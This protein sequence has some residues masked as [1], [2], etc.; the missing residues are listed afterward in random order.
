MA[1]GTSRQPLYPTEA[2]RSRARLTRMEQQRALIATTLLGAVA[3]AVAS[4]LVLAFRWVIEDGQRLFLPNGELGAYEQL[5]GW[6]V[7]LLPLAGGVV[8]GLL[9]ERLDPQL[10]EVG[11]LHVLRRI[12]RPGRVTLPYGNALVQFFGGAFAVVCGHS[13]DREGPGVHLGSAAGNL[14]GRFIGTSGV[15]VYTLTACGAAASI[16]AAFNTPLAGVVFVIE[17]LHVRYRIERFI[18]IIAASV[19]GAIIS[20]ARYGDSPAFEVIDLRTGSL[21][22]FFL[23]A[24]LGVVLGILAVAFVSGT[25]RL[26]RTT[27]GWRPLQ[28]FACAGAVTGLIGLAYPQ[29]LGISYDTLSAILDNRLGA[30]L[31]TGLIVAKLLATAVAVGLR[32]PGGLIGP[33]LVIGGAAGA[34][35]GV[36][37]PDWVGFATGSE[38]FYGAMGMMAM[39]AAVLQ[40]PLA[41]LFALLELTADPHIILPGMTVVVTADLVAR[42]LLGR[43][44]VFDYLRRQADEREG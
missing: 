36:A 19:I 34:A 25:D 3:G 26:A 18:P 16:A 17:V 2:A 33:S 43:D 12:K 14:L 11:I 22:E 1:G 38:S 4:L 37:A 7:L 40:A 28:A 29:V 10:R 5:P 24:A 23:L 35:V 6:T 30:Q 8:L 15:N 31:L 42:Q 13:V 21:Y 39:M 20:R 32:V 27:R 9:F 41:A 44:S